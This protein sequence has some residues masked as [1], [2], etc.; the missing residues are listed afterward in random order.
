MPLALPLVDAPWLAQSADLVG[1]QGIG[2]VLL[3]ATVAVAVAART[4]VRRTVLSAG[5]WLLLVLGL[6][7]YGRARIPVVEAARDRADVLRVGL[8]QP[9]IPATLRWRP[10][11]AEPIRAHLARL[12]VGLL[13]RS[14]TVIFWHEGAFPYRLP[15]RA[16]RD[17]AS[18]APVLP[19]GGSV[20]GV[21]EWPV[22][23]FGSVAEALDGAVYNAAFVRE[24]DGTLER[25]VAKRILVPFGEYIPG[26]RF[27]P[28][29]RRWFGRAEGLHPGERPEILTVAGRTVGVLN[30]FEDTIPW[31]GAEV[32]RADLLVNLTNDAWFD[33]AAPAQHML[34]AR[35]RAIEARRDLVRAVNTGYS[36]H[37]DALGRVVTLLPAGFPAAEMVFPRVGL[38]LHPWAPRFIVTAPW[39][40]LLAVGIT[41][42]VRMTMRLR[43]PR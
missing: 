37:I 6:T 38:G 29:L 35:W 31:A 42:G 25:P 33:G 39:L 2:A 16:G 12:T 17:G 7:V 24:P 28:F 5:V 13:G 34:N 36:T 3:G 14:P 1:V 40:A 4:R 15:Y 27:V 18:A 9:V 19:M 30:C 8:V 21:R 41:L 23:V 26:V 10:E 11:N 43:R 20:V 22:L 32:A